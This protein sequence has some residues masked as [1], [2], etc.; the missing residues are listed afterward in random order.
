MSVYCSLHPCSEQCLTALLTERFSLM[1]LTARVVAAKRTERLSEYSLMNAACVPHLSDASDRLAFV[2]LCLCVSVCVC[3]S[4]SGTIPC[5]CCHDE[6]KGTQDLRSILMLILR[7]L[8]LTA[9]VGAAWRL[10]VCVCVCDSMASLYV[11]V[12]VFCLCLCPMP[13]TACVGAACRLCLT[14]CVGAA[15]SGWSIWKQLQ[16]WRPQCR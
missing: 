11:H 1:P 12:S 2:C 15:W 9:R 16:Q 6:I 8:S 7:I 5:T 3:V 14:A 13:L 4:H 10:C